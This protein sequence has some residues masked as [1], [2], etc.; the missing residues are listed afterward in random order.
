MQRQS[1]SQWI[2]LI[3]SLLFN[4][5]MLVG[6]FRPLCLKHPV[7]NCRREGAA[8]LLRYRAAPCPLSLDPQEGFFFIF[9]RR[10]EVGLEKSLPDQMSLRFLV[11]PRFYSA[12]TFKQ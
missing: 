8:V 10:G 3:R 4:I 9:L 5:E 6:W 1:Q 11:L 12:G 7:T 2:V